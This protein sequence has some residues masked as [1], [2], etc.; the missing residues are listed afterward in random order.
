MRVL[1]VVGLLAAF[2]AGLSFGSYTRR[3]EAGRREVFWQGL[4]SRCLVRESQLSEEAMA[5]STDL[6][7]ARRR[8]DRSCL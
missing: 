7:M 5:C 2:S 8:C 6:D 3:V 4:A 1:Y